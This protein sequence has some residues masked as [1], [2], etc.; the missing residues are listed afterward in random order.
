MRLDITRLAL[1][2]PAV[3][4]FQRDGGWVDYTLCS[5]WWLESQLEPVFWGQPDTLMLSGNYIDPVRGFRF[6]GRLTTQAIDLNDL[7]IVSELRRVSAEFRFYPWGKQ[8]PFW[9]VYIPTSMYHIRKDTPRTSRAEIEL[10]GTRILSPEETKNIGVILEPRVGFSG[11][12]PWEITATWLAMITAGEI[13]VRVRDTEGNA[14][15]ASAHVA[16]G[17]LM[18]ITE[19]LTSAPTAAT[20]SHSATPYEKEVSL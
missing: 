4:S 2:T 11:Q 13:L 20:F 17:R 3:I 14:D 9:N 10:L 16:N 8:R 6:R 19:N 7:G 1:R 15:Q 5:P 18:F 12:G